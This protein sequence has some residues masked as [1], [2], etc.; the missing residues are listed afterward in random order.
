MLLYLLRSGR[1]T[2]LQIIVLKLGVR[3][4]G[5]HTCREHENQYLH[6][7]DVFDIGSIIRHLKDTNLS[8]TRVFFL[9]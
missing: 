6:C 3:M 1:N 7:P 8:A 5:I 4:P 9:S 2:V